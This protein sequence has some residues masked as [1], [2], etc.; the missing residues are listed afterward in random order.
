MKGTAMNRWIIG[1]VAMLALVGPVG[2][3]EFSEKI[4]ASYD[5]GALKPTE[6]LSG[7]IVRH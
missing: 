6:I 2:A 7:H 1:V 4:W 3:S 5:A